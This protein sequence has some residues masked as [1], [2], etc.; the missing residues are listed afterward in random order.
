MSWQFRV[1][2]WW[3]NWLGLPAAA[4]QT[5]GLFALDHID[6]VGVLEVRGDRRSSTHRQTSSLSWR[7]NDWAMAAT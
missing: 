2:Q 7:E 4:I 5:G 1:D 6:H 3:T